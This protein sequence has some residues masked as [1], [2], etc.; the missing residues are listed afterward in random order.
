MYLPRRPGDPEIVVGKLCSVDAGGIWL[1]FKGLAAEL[2][3]D[4]K[5]VGLNTEDE[6]FLPYSG[7]RAVLVPKPEATEGPSRQ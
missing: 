3:E 2:A 7:I 1:E 4:F 6:F 5:A